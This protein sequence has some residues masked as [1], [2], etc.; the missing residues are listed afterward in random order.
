LAGFISGTED[1]DL[2]RMFAEARIYPLLT[3]EQ[4]RSIDSDKWEAIAKLQQILLEDPASRAFLYSWSTNC[5]APLPK[6]ELFDLREQHFLLRRDLAAVLPGS[7]GADN[8]S[9]FRLMLHS[10]TPAKQANDALEALSLPASLVEG[11]TALILHSADDRPLSGVADALEAWTR[12]WD[13]A[14]ILPEGI[15]ITQPTRARCL[16]L[17]KEY[18]SARDLLILHNLR[19]VYSIAGRYRGRGMA[20]L[21]LVQEGTLGLLRAAEKF[22]HQ[23]GYRFSTYCFNWISQAIRRVVSESSGIIRYPGHVNEQL[24]KL[25]GQRA[26][27]VARTG[28]TPG[29]TQLASALGLTTQKTRDLLQLRNLGVSLSSPQFD[30]SDATTLADTLPAA[31][32][33]QPLANAESASL[34]RC[35]LSEIK[36]LEPA[37]QQVVINRWGLH[38]GRALSRAEIADKMAVSREWVRQL[39]RSALN[40]LGQN[41]AVRSA[42]TSHEEVSL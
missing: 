36:R 32:C 33:D 34:K 18:T 19:L 10:K 13:I 39:E 16:A 2:E 22:Q 8:M 15:N 29:D 35:L 17:L 42:Y 5:M 30:D 21:D 27:E 31:P 25:Y 14:K 26:A 28:V 24:G 3:R 6:I 12:H 38:Q 4:E 40:K 41:A 37:E 1:K 20:F 9:S 23:R 7:V 11:M